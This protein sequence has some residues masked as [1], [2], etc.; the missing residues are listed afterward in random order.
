LET[1]T[2]DT[3][4]LTG[5]I[6]VRAGQTG[7]RSYI[8]KSWISGWNHS[9]LARALGQSYY[10]SYAPIMERQYARSTVRVA[11][12]CEEPGAI[13]G[14]AVLE[15]AASLVHFVSVRDRWR[16]KGVASLL[17]ASELGRTDIKYTHS[18]PPH[19]KA[20]FGWTYTPLAGAGLEQS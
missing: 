16:R 20:P 9:T 10:K 19:I 7:D 17:L 18:L 1:L 13:M 5:V 14:F 6:K 2:P 12:L 11:C 8:L 4:A 3:S 15:P